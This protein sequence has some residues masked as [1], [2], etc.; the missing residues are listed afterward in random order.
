MRITGFSLY[1]WEKKLNG[2]YFL[3]YKTKQQSIDLKDL[4]DL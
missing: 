3:N 2:A 1:F 4:K